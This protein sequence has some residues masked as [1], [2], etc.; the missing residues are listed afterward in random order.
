[1]SGSI[2]WTPSEHYLFRIL[3]FSVGSTIGVTTGTAYGAF[4]FFHMT[5]G[6]KL[7]VSIA[8]TGFSG[9]GLDCMAVRTFL[10]FGAFT[11]HYLSIFPHVVAKG[12]IFNPGLF[13]VGVM[14]KHCGGT[15]MR[16]ERGVQQNGYF[17]LTECGNHIEKDTS[18]KDRHGEY[19]FQHFHLPPIPLQAFP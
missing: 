7:V 4:V 18:G 10:V 17:I 9:L 1:M 6:A 3:V 15:L 16:L 8:Q 2:L 11:F 14:D 19:F 12:A 13:I 5:A